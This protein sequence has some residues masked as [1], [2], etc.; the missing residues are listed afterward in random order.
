[1]NN[2]LNLTFKSSFSSSR[3]AVRK[4][5]T[6]IV[7]QIHEQ[8]EIPLREIIAEMLLVSSLIICEEKC[9]IEDCIKIDFSA[10]IEDDDLEED[11]EDD[12]E[13]RLREEFEKSE[14][15]KSFE[16]FE[17]EEYRL[18][19][20]NKY[21]QLTKYSETLIKALPLHAK[22][23]ISIVGNSDRYHLRFFYIAEYLM[24]CYVVL[25]D[26]NGLN[27][28]M[29]VANELQAILGDK[30]NIEFF[31]HDVKRFFKDISTFG[32]IHEFIKENPNI[33]QKKI[34]RALSLEGRKI[35]YMFDYANKLEKIFRVRYKD[36]W[37][38]NAN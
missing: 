25:Q 22:T 30:I 36:T 28:L 27:N 24:K 12:V 9:D 3:L 11:E 37:L 19:R 16:L 4:T 7:R 32:I 35:A 14:I 10:E 34:A 1:M 38:L 5:L 29:N 17:D 15:A 31:E 13:Y 23:Y 8:Q 2:Q 20:L 21:T 18:K 26:Y 6:D 33:E